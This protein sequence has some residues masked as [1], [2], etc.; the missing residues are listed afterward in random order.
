[1]TPVGPRTPFEKLV[2]YSVKRSVLQLMRVWRSHDAVT[3]DHEYFISPLSGHIARGRTIRHERFMN[4]RL[5]QIKR[6]ESEQES[7]EVGKLSEED[8]RN[9]G[10]EDGYSIWIKRS[11]NMDLYYN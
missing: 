2:K 6:E 8:Q 3:T 11:E 5:A 9:A 7:F 1:M 10:R 4:R